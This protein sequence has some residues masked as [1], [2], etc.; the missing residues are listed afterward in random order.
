MK[1][2]LNEKKHKRSINVDNKV[3]VELSTDTR[4]MP[5][6]DAQGTLDQYNQY[7]KEKDESQKYRLIFTINPFCSN[8]L[9]NA[10]TEIVYK[11]GSEE[12]RFFGKDG[13]YMTPSAVRYYNYKMNESNQTKTL[14]REEAI[15][16][17]AYS[18]PDIGPYVYH[19]GYDIFNNHTLRKKEFNV[20]TPIGKDKKAEG[21]NTIK[22][23]MRTYDGVGVTRL[24]E[25]VTV[26]GDGETP[27]NNTLRTDGWYS[28]RLYNMGNIMS[29]AESIEENLV[30]DKGWMGFINPTTLGITNYKYKD[31]DGNLHEVSI[32]KCMN[33]NKA[34]E[35]IDMYPD[36]SLYSFVPKVNKYRG[37]TEANWDYCLTYPYRSTTLSAVTDV[38]EKT[39][40]VKNTVYHIN[41]LKA[42]TV[43]V[44]LGDG[45]LDGD[46]GLEDVL[47]KTDLRN[48][49]TSKSLIE[50]TIIGKTVSGETTVYTIDTSINVVSVGHNGEDAE[51][52][53]T[54]SY[55]E[56]GQDVEQFSEIEEYRIRRIYNTIPC[57][58]YFRMFKRIPNFANTNVY[59][60]EKISSEE[61]D[62]YANRD[63]CSSLNKLAFGKSIYS[64]D[65]VQIVFTDDVDLKGLQ[66]NLGRQVSEVYLTIVKRNQGHDLWY[67]EKK[68]T[69]TTD[70]TVE[71][72]HCFS[73]VT[74]G[75]DMPYDY[76]T[77]SVERPYNIHT[78][79]NIGNGEE[80]F[81]NTV[82][83]IPVASRPL[84]G[85]IVISGN[86]YNE[87]LG[88][89]VEFIPSRLEEITIE[90]VYHRFNT[91][92]REYYA[93]KEYQ[94]IKYDDIVY[95][96]DDVYNS[97]SVQNVENFKVTGL[98]YNRS[99]TEGKL[100]DANLFPEGYYYQPHYKVALR[101]YSD[102]I[103]KGTHI[104][105]V[106]RE[107][108][109]IGTDTYS[110]LTSTNYYFEMGDEMYLYNVITNEKVTGW[111]I[112]IE[113]K[114]F[115]EITF[116]LTSGITDFSQYKIYRRNPERPSNA[117]EL[118]D[119]S[120][121]YVWRDVKPSSEIDTD[122]ELY[123]S[124]FTNGA[125]YF[126]KNINFYLKRQDPLGVYG[127]SYANRGDVIQR[128]QKLDISGEYTDVSGVETIEEDTTCSSM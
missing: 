17:T 98:T 5:T 52:Y 60:D 106:T 99:V 102:T 45:K 86:C 89:I 8:V 56:I 65:T 55:E 9:F 47:F 41:G 126:Q 124:T 103:N 23:I 93:D 88:D 120:G 51:H 92:Q 44:E 26:G 109:S 107:I 127:L 40:E 48:N 119:G 4:V 27:S 2:L 46:S 53:F 66:D 19:C 16:D 28:A 30:E 110:A 25:K 122:S 1:I 95:D 11:E 61:I 74:S 128:V 34:C 29:F 31:E 118:N 36:R 15:R 68:Y 82:F 50:L 75:L 18:H 84:E 113:G 64:D 123:D 78:T 37:R 32:N 57:K 42:H 73:K 58:Y 43:D 117:Y 97:D 94:S 71:F 62:K 49:L 116:K 21:F 85:D 12:C 6:G 121:I 108:G 13:G 80:V 112:K 38:V 3:N 63:F 114:N 111:V 91:A 76:Y 72:S 33:N 22:D 105:V 20:V 67:K 77:E 100:Y 7:L 39:V 81:P 70:T 24:T 54:L 59:S 101:E 125:H 69:D 83:D 115:N 35:Q 10:V 79:H 87:F 90:K 96:T 14:T 104:R